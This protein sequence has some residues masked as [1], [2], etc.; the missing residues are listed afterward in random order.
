MTMNGYWRDTR[1]ENRR[2]TLNQYG[3][4]NNVWIVAP[5]GGPG[6]LGGFGRSPSGTFSSFADLKPHLRS[7]DIVYVFGVVRE[8]FVTPAGVYDVTVLGAANQARQATS[9]GVPTGG[10][11]SWL[12]PAAPTALTPLVEVIAQGWVFQNIEFN[13]TTS[14]AAIRLTRSAVVDATDASHAQIVDCYFLGGGDGQIGIED[15]GGA[16]FVLVDGCRF[17]ALTGTAILGLN[18]AS[19]VPQDWRIV[20]CIFWQNTNDIKMSLNYSLLQNNQHMTAGSG[21]TNKVVSTV[22]VSGQGQNNKV[23]LNFFHNSAATVQ[24]SNGYSGSAT[25]HWANYAIATAALIVV[26]PPG[27]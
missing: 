18:T 14:A 21:A 5:Q 25:D 9:G 15:N 24:I 13:P 6:P 20:N 23:V 4:I 12:P 2:A 16:S 27:A 22:A 19:N 10:G 17:Q 3:A 26:S 7:R 11:A 1:I 8:H